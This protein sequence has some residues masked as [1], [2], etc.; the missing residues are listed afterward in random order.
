MSKR[1]IQPSG[2][3]SKIGKVFDAADFPD[4]TIREDYPAPPHS[5]YLTVDKTAGAAL[6]DLTLGEGIGG[7]ACTRRFH[8]D[9][10]GVWLSVAGWRF[11]KLDIVNIPAGV[12]LRYTWL[13]QPYASGSLVA[14]R[15]WQTV[16]AGALSAPMPDGAVAVTPDRNEAGAVWRQTDGAGTFDIPAALAAGNRT[17]L[18]GSQLVFAAPLGAPL[19]LCWELDLV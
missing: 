14:A 12:T 13:T 10:R 11:V 1:T 17:E 4:T 6:V 5:L 8:V 16:A 15:F 3:R 19:V 7:G 9:G 18:R 2:T